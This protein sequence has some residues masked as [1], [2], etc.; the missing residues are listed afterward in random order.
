M[1]LVI[2]DERRINHLG[3]YMS[4]NM[5]ME[6][7]TEN[8]FDYTFEVGAR[9]SEAQAPSEQQS[10]LQRLQHRIISSCAALGAPASVAA[11]SAIHLAAPCAA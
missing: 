2:D 5:L 3:L 10:L 11:A 7:G 8:A 4:I 1:D 6:F 9:P